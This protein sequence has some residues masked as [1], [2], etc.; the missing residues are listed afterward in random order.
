MSTLRKKY[1]DR[2]RAF[3]FIWQNADEDGIWDGDAASLVG[4]FNVSEDAAH[5]I[6]CELCDRR[7]IEGLYSAKYLIVKWRERKSSMKK[8]LNGCTEAKHHSTPR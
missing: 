8:A 6:L 1:L 4:G 3:E 5:S 2:E 7:H